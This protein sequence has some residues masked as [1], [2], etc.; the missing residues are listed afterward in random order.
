IGAELK[1]VVFPSPV[2]TVGELVDGHEENRG[3]RERNDAVNS[4][5]KNSRVERSARVLPSLPDETPAKIVDEFGINERGQSD[6]QTLAVVQHGRSWALA[7][8]LVFACRVAV[9]RL[10]GQK[11]G[12]SADLYHMPIEPRDVFVSSGRAVPCRRVTERIA[13]AFLIFIG[14]AGLPC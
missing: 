13:I 9:V 7:G 6:G 11:Q 5:Q 4:I 2:Q 10:S 1:C 12:F 14:P 8:S 3:A